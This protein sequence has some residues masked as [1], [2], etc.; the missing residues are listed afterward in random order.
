MVQEAW[1][2]RKKSRI[3]EELDTPNSI[4][5]EFSVYLKQPVVRLK[6]SP[7][8]VWTEIVHKDS[9]LLKM[10]KKYLCVMATSVPC[11]RVFSA[12]GNIA[13]CK[14]SCLLGEKLHKLLFL[15]SVDKTFWG[16]N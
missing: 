12:S 13:N 4:P 7:F 1:K 15:K 8:E 2:S 6:D 16:H 10:V 3:V 11:E 14:R 5:P 9:S